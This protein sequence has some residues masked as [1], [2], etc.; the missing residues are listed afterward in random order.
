[1]SYLAQLTTINI[2]KRNNICKSV[3]LQGISELLSG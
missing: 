3:L 2:L 1:M